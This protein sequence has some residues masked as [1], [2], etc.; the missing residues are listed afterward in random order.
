MIL[1]VTTFPTILNFQNYID[2]SDMGDL[3]G[4]M[5]LVVQL[6]LVIEYVFTGP[7]GLVLKNLSKLL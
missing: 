6:F 5:C 7:F 4:V 1:L 3:K 2:D